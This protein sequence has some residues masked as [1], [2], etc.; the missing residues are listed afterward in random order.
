M[1]V[2]WK[3]W[4]GVVLIVIS[5]CMWCA[6]D[7]RF[8]KSRRFR[9]KRKVSEIFWV[10]WKFLSSD[11]IGWLRRAGGSSGAVRVLVVV[12]L[13]QF[14]S[15]CATRNHGTTPP[16]FW[17]MSQMENLM[18]AFP[19]FCWPRCSAPTQADCCLL[20]WKWPVFMRNL[21]IFFWDLMRPLVGKI[22]QNHVSCHCCFSERWH[23]SL[24]GPCSGSRSWNTCCQWN[25]QHCSCFHHN[26]SIFWN[27]CDDHDA[28]VHLQSTV[29]E[30]VQSDCGCQCRP[31]TQNCHCCWTSKT[32]RIRRRMP[33]DGGAVLWLAN[34]HS[35]KTVICCW[36][37][38]SN[39]LGQLKANIVQHSW[40]QCFLQ[41]ESLVM[42]THG[43]IW[44]MWMRFPPLLLFP[45]K[46]SLFC[47]NVALWRLEIC[48]KHFFLDAEC[49]T[50]DWIQDWSSM[51][52]ILLQTRDVPCRWTLCS[53]NWCHEVHKAEWTKRCGD[54]KI[55]NAK[56]TTLPLPNFELMPAIFPSCWGHWKWQKSTNKTGMCTRCPRHAI[57]KP[58]NNRQK[59]G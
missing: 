3:S 20:L 23:N 30:W 27:C 17:S 24:V 56:R 13:V 41:E 9:P 14:L 15:G 36:P 43:T 1:F 45:T 47:S 8:W 46:V 42:R 54:G 44:W 52:A 33:N 22:P 11:F 39:A 6:L 21:G 16:P 57:G 26:K 50:W 28:L 18:L 59:W 4:F 58:T 34:G 29:R 37:L 5:A 32:P 51:T 35:H 12:K 2:F 40:Q 31:A 7:F 25:R 19:L 55:A 38:C 10:F 49:S 48:G 53:Q